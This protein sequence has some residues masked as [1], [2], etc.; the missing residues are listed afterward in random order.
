MSCNQHQRTGGQRALQ[1]AKTFTTRRINAFP[2]SPIHDNSPPNDAR[3]ATQAVTLAP[4]SLAKRSNTLSAGA[5]ASSIFWAEPP[6]KF[7]RGTKQTKRD[8]RKWPKVRGSP[9]PSGQDSK[10]RREPSQ[11]LVQDR[12]L[13][14]EQTAW[15]VPRF[16]RENSGIAT[17][18]PRVE[19]SS[20]R[21]FVPRL[22]AST[23]QAFDRPPTGT[24]RQQQK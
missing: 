9:I 14:L 4:N 5:R 16:S 13:P 22:A 10:V 2:R 20:S 7:K 19:A 23:T 3:P 12:H 1:F 15:D 6:K 18:R 21:Q 8:E 24:V 17:H 11:D